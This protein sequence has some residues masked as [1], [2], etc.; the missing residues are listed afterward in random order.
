M[1]ALAFEAG[2]P[3]FLLR[4]GKKDRQIDR[5]QISESIFYKFDRVRHGLRLTNRDDFFDYG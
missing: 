3:S 4:I 1:D 5:K 2:T